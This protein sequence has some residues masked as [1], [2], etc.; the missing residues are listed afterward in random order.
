V[1]VYGAVPPPAVEV[2]VNGLP[3]VAAPQLRLLV[4]GWPATLTVAEALAV[5]L[6]V[7][8]SLATLVIERLPFGEQVTE[9]VLV[10]DVPVHPV[11]NV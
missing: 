11:G 6:P 9:I 1:N 8:L 5:A 10:V 7:L 4:T 3:T 2:Q